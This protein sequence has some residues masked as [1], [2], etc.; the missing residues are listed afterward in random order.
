MTVSAQSAEAQSG[1]TMV[2]AVN[3]YIGSLKDEQ[4]TKCLFPFESDERTNWIF[5]PKLRE[6]LTLKAMTMPQRDM[7]TD[8]LKTALSA[9]GLKKA[10]TIRQLENV[11]LAIEKGSGPLRDPENYYIS[12][13]G[14]PSM[15]GAW[16]WRYEGHHCSLQ[17]T[18][19]DGKVIASTPQFFGSNPAE[20][21]IES[22]MKGT[23]IMA[24]EEDLARSLLKSLKPDQLK[25]AII[26][27]KAPP[28][29]LTSNNRV[30]AIQED[31]GIA[32][33]ELS[34]EQQGMLMTV[35]KE[36][37]D[38]QAPA[39]SKA[40]VNKLVKAGVDT[41]K[42]AWMGGPD[43][44]QPHYYRVQGKTFLIEYD[45]TQNEANHVHLVWRDFNGDFGRDL[46]AEHYKSAPGSHGHDRH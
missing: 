40:R 20:V 7:V 37:A 31:K 29:V 5:V 14:T 43:K 45:N 30:A 16:G 34:A 4:K 3:K 19:I 21:R 26:S 41:I 10:E 35:I 8:M 22:P 24:L 32:F 39:L 1:K 42:F 25:T 17:W 27:E 15:K 28:D 46:L 44:G 2:D 33:K 11:L 9:K 6:G 13:F 18:M 38:A 12:I 36:V 23:R